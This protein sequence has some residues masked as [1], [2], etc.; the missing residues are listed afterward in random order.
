[1]VPN[2]AT[3]TLL[4]IETEDLSEPEFQSTRVLGIRPGPGDLSDRRLSAQ[5]AMMLF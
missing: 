5:E 1:M 2:A 4:S 3:P